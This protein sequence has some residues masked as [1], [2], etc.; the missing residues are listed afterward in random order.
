MMQIGMLQTFMA[1]NINNIRLSLFP[2]II[3]NNPD[4]R[5]SSF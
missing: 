5:K 4:L 3:I 1:Q 2:V